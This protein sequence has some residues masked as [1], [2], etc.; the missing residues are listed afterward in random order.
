[1]IIIKT[2]NCPLCEYSLKMSVKQDN[3][4]GY[5]VAFFDGRDKKSRTTITKCPRCHTDLSQTSILKTLTGLEAA[6]ITTR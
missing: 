3:K 6:Q 4:A 5:T 1:M 2:T